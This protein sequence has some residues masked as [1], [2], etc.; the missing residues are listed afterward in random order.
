MHCDFFITEFQLPQ[1]LLPQ[2][3][4]LKGWTRLW[5]KLECQIIKN[6]F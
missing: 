1:I 5:A 4:V 3:D 6:I 2:T